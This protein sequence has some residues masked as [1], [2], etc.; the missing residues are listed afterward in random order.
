MTVRI[1]VKLR[2]NTNLNNNAG[3]PD[4][5]ILVMPIF[6]IHRAQGVGSTATHLA[7]KR[8]QGLETT[9]PL[10]QNGYWGNNGSDPNY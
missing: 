4:K 10:I 2:L 5:P 8:R 9:P 6:I 3:E 7:A 1:I